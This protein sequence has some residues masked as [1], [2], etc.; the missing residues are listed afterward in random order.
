MNKQDQLETDI[1]YFTSENVKMASGFREKAIYET[2]FRSATSLVFDYWQNG[3]DINE[4]LLNVESIASFI[5]N[6]AAG[7][8]VDNAVK[9][10]KRKKKASSRKKSK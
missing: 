4:A 10:Q 1:I 3:L 2:A 8:K 9:K 7:S 5:D 6:N